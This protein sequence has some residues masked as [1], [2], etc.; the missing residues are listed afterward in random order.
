MSKCHFYVERDILVVSCGTIQANVRS[1]YF[2]DDFVERMVRIRVR[3]SDQLE[4]VFKSYC[5]T[6]P[7]PLSDEAI[8]ALERMSRRETGLKSPPGHRVFASKIEIL[9]LTP[10]VFSASCTAWPTA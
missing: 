6:L 5:M 4:D 7:V 9:I 3:L 8:V 10:R 1:R 2:S